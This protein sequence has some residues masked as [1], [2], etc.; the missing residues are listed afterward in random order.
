MGAFFG[1]FTDSSEWYVQS[2]P[3]L[4][5]VILELGLPVN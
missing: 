4:E 3:Y 1:W 5:G 2:V